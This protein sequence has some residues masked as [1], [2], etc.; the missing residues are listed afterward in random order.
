MIKLGN[1]NLVI[2]TVGDHSLHRHW[3]DGGFDT[4]LVYFGD[5]AGYEGESKYHKRTKGYKYPLISDLLDERPELFDYQYIWLPDDDV[6]ATAKDIAHMFDMMAQYDLWVA[7]P[8]LM[9]YYGVD[10]TLHQKASVLRYTNWVEIMCP[11][12]S[13]EALR[14]CKQTFKEN[15]TGWSIESIW[16]VLLGH[17]RDKIAILDDVVVTHTRP[18]LTGET[19]KGRADPL[20]WAVSEALEVFRKWDLN[21]EMGKDLNHGRPCGGEVKHAVMYRQIRKPMEE[22]IDKRERCWPDCAVFQ[23]RLKSLAPQP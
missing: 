7:Q 4:F 9:G 19:Y 8:S 15:S 11:C 1:R 12:F 22:G 14:T 6:Y 3:I 16:G 10:I 17:P 5:G 13:S 2:S 18:V 20:G 23:E 21:N